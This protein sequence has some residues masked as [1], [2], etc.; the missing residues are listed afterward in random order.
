MTELKAGVIGVGY[1]GRF[2]AQ[3]YAAQSGVTLVGVADAR[4]ETAQKVAAEL[5]CAAFT[6]YRELMAQVD[7]VSIAATTETHYEIA[8]A[9]LEAGKHVLVEKPITVTVAEAEE[10]ARIARERGL[11]LQVGHIER[12]SPVWRAV[13]GR[14]GQPMFIE[15]HRMAPFKP[16]GIDVSVV[17]DLMIHDIDL[18]LNKVDSP[19]AEL[20]A[21]GASVLTDRTDIANARIEFENGC[22]ANLTASRVSLGVMRK[23]RLFQADGYLSIDFQERR[24]TFGRKA[25]NPAEGEAPITSEVIEVPAGDAL[26]SEVSAFVE[27]VQAGSRPV[28]AGEDGKRA[29]EV[30]LEVNR[31]IES[32]RK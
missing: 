14:I 21:N 16:R 18:V 11:K 28:V 1:L 30:A 2:H 10:L 9:C 20:R 7:L 27:S 6:E 5:G 25:E 31:Q 4:A 8:R 29:L 32:R 12:F 19:I 3:K 24:V 13:E 15:A 17:L 23:M 22:T 26:M